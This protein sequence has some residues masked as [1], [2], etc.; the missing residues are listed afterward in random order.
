[1]NVRSIRL[2]AASISLALVATSAHA[3]HI[4]PN[5]TGQVLLF[6]YYTV[7]NGFSTLVSV[8]NTQN[9][10]KAVKVRFLE[11]MN[12]REVS[13]FN[14]F[15]APNDTWTGAVVETQNGARIVT[16]DNSCVA[17]SDL[18]TE[19]RKISAT[20]QSFNE[21]INIRFSGSNQD[22][23]AFSSLDRTREGYFEI[24]EMGVID[25]TLSA[26]ATQ[27]VGFVKPADVDRG[28]STN[29]AAVDRFDSLSGTQ[30]PFRFPNTGAELMAPPSGGL[31]GRASL[32]NAA[33]GANYSFAPTA[34]DGWSSQ[35][36]YSPA[37]D[38]GG[39]LL[40][41]A[42][43][44]SSMVTTPMGVVIA[45]WANGRDA[46]SAALMRESLLNEFVLDTGTV[47]QT[48]WLVTL[49]TKRFY[50]DPIYGNSNSSVRAPFSGAFSSEGTTGCDPYAASTSNRDGT[51]RAFI[52]G[53]RPP[54]PLGSG[55]PEL[56]RITNIVPFL[57]TTPSGAFSV[58]SLLGSPTLSPA[59]FYEVYLYTAA[60]TSKASALTSPAFSG[61]TQGPNG[62]ATFIFSRPQQQLTPLSAVLISPSG[63][64]TTISGKHI[65]LPMIGVMLHNYKNA[66][67]LSRYG[68]VVEHAY[69]VRV[70]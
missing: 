21:F 9:N 51:R 11:G 6:P 69:S 59:G 66:D 38:A 46:V 14:L 13:G 29:C 50:T 16:N 67:V 4:S 20:G 22:N 58:S 32:I 62:R 17:P 56:C 43:P 52:F 40:S 19:T 31:K 2:F 7:R 12:G 34:L 30:N 54:A 37:G 15:L 47:S 42:F 3:V 65:G 25:P 1:M 48:D 53:L 70:E 8:T 41:D 44:T 63:V 10:T 68:G 26:T 64:Q 23:P 61:S 60:S 57:T 33:T 5:G 49:P 27:I 35:V 55:A 45:R 24:L 39:T 36:A 18:F 28:G